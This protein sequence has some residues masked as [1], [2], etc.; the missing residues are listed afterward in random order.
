MVQRCI[1]QL[2]IRVKK[3]TLTEQKECS[4]EVIGRT[5]AQHRC[6]HGSTVGVPNREAKGECKEYG[7]VDC[8]IVEEWVDRPFVLPRALLQGQREI[9]RS[10][11][12]RE[13]EKD[14]RPPAKVWWEEIRSP[15]KRRRT[16][17][18]NSQGKIVLTLFC[19]S[20]TLFLLLLRFC[21]GEVGDGFLEGYWQSMFG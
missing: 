7:R 13:R 3:W 10:G 17:G 2:D 9:G 8:R 4:R 19:L 16:R 12:V 5:A 15:A 6:H 14:I 20:Y 11:R 1:V 18:N 21:S